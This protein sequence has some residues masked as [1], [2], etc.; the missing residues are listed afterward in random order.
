VKKNYIRTI[1]AFS[2]SLILASCSLLGQNTSSAPLTASGTIE[3][4]TVDLASEIGGKI[5]AINVQEGDSVTS[6]TQLFQLDDSI[7]QAQLSQA[8]ASLQAAQASQAVAQ[9]N[10]ELLQAG[11]T[12][13]QIQAAQDQ[14]N[15]AQANLKAVQASIS[16]MTADSR[17]EDVAAARARLDYARTDYYS[18]TVVL[19]TDQIENVDQA[20]NQATSNLSLAQERNTSLNADKR[21]PASAIAASAANIA[22]DQAIVNQLTVAYQ[23][24]QNANLPFY[25]QIQQVKIGRDLANLH[26]SKAQARQTNLLADP[27]MTQEAKDAAQ[28][29][30]DETQTLLDMCNTAYDSLSA[31]DQAVQLNSA[32]TNLQSALNDLNSL[33]INPS[34]GP[35]LESM[36]NQLDA[37]TAQRDVANANLQNL[38]SGARSQQIAAAQAQVSAAGD[39]VASA[40]AAIDLINIQIGKLKVSSPVQG[41]VLD[42]PFSVAEIA[43]A[44]ATVVEIGSLDT[45]TLTVYVPEDQYGAVKLGQKAVVTVDSFPGKSFDGVVNYIS[46]QAEFTPRNVQTAQSRSTTVYAVKISLPNPNHDLKPGM[47][48]DAVFQASP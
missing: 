15:Q 22:D 8:N 31:G 4:N 18:M 36:L 21:N 26:L 40:Q 47:P 28:A 24:V 13:T 48:A 9:A 39:Q 12:N 37:A 45:V 29:A 34:G 19:N 11:A 14:L 33:G 16:A 2:L 38:H 5:L 43:P 23:D 7:L 10:L 30:V 35:T 27:N 46:N 6:G 17:P 41:V 25:Q 1:Y 32:W 44:G 3:A 42:V 20:L